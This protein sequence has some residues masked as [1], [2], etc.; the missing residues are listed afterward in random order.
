MRIEAD[1]MEDAMPFFICPPLGQ[2]RARLCV[3]VSTFT[4]TIYGNHAR[5]DY[6]PEWQKRNTE[7]NAYPHNPVEYPQYGLSTYNYHSDGSGICHASHLRP[8]FNLRQ[9]T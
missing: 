5:P 2:P 4:Y 7:W 8:L 1:G 3:L 9:A 6:E